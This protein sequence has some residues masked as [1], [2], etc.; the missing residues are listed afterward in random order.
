MRRG[1]VRSPQRSSTT[2]LVVRLRP[3]WQT[4]AGTQEVSAIEVR[5]VGTAGFE[6]ATSC[7]PRMIW[8][9]LQSSGNH[10][11]TSIIRHFVVVCN[12]TTKLSLLAVLCGKRVGF[13]V[14]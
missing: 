1:M 9:T 11:N 12:T 10:H 8:A 14:T 6:P 13:V 2:P 5:G 3:H 7:T 4:L